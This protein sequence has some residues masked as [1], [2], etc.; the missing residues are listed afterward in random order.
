[1]KLILGE[2]WELHG[3][4][5]FAP[6]REWVASGKY[7]NVLED[8]LQALGIKPDQPQPEQEPVDQPEE[9]PAE[10]YT[11]VENRLWAMGQKISQED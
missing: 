9:D 5:A 6:K 4:D 11:G 7:A 1:M 10:D 3:L 8:W 2:Q